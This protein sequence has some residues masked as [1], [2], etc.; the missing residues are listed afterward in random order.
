VRE[1]ES[2]SESEREA[3]RERESVC[4]KERE[5]H[6]YECT[7]ECS[8]SLLRCLLPN[9]LCRLLFAS[10]SIVVSASQESDVLAVDTLYD[11]SSVQ[12]SKVTA[13]QSLL[14]STRSVSVDD[15]M[16]TADS[17]VNSSG[18]EETSATNAHSTVKAMNFLLEGINDTPTADEKTRDVVYDLNLGHPGMF[19]TVIMKQSPV[20]A[21]E[22]RKQEQLQR[23]LHREAAAAVASSAATSDTASATT[24]ITTST[25]ATTI[26]GPEMSAIDFLTG[27]AAGSQ[28][29]REQAA[30]DVYD[31]VLSTG[32]L[33]RCTLCR[34]SRLCWLSTLGY[35]APHSCLLGS[36]LS[37]HLF[38][39]SS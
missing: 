1:R 35:A 13:V 32:T 14:S 28:P 39:R 34:V 11:L 26:S 38:V 27:A 22:N 7:C 5:V 3:E 8:F 15:L 25:S 9:A 37:V 10:L 19:G 33:A 24:P 23:K 30:S 16:D 2:E 29:E 36:F 17:L 12:V 18:A 6:G 4:V 31:M 21:A 20:V